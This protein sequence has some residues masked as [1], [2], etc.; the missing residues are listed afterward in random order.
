MT[1]LTVLAETPRIGT[2]IW[3]EAGNVC[4][5][6]KTGRDRKTGQTLLKVACPQ[7]QKV[8]PLKAIKGCSETH[9]LKKG[10]RCG[11]VFDDHRLVI[12]KIREDGICR[13]YDLDKK[14]T[15]TTH[16]N[17]LIAIARI[18]SPQ[19]RAGDLD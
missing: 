5:V 4:Q 9:P 11:W 16:I 6:V 14:K 3:D 8:V 1:A 12:E 2:W 17:C 18:S 10:D 15:M 7:G 19:G 13:V